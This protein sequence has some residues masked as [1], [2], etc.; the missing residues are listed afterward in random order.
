ME[1]AKFT[2][3]TEKVTAER[4]E[5]IAPITT[6]VSEDGTVTVCIGETP[7]NIEGPK[8]SKVHLRTDQWIALKPEAIGA[9]P[10]SG[11]FVRMRE[12]HSKKA[13]ELGESLGQAIQE[14]VDNWLR[15]NNLT[16]HAHWTAGT[17]NTDP[18]AT[19]WLG[20]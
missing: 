5:G 15:E 16:E 2:L 4:L 9:T 14:T 10:E 8:W 20:S 18:G 11:P 1:K 13:K 12:E 7:N 3:G 6:K 17:N 19:G